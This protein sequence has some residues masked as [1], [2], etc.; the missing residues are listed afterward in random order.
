MPGSKKA[1]SGDDFSDAEL[2]SSS[3]D[4]ED[5]E[6]DPDGDSEIPPQKSS[7]V[8]AKLTISTKLKENFNFPQ[9]FSILPDDPVMISVIMGW[10]FRGYYDFGEQ[11]FSIKFFEIFSKSKFVGNGHNLVFLGFISKSFGI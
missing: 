9:S 7:K 4:D 2:E 8:C 6:G 11:L 1:K 5:V 3:S 10:G